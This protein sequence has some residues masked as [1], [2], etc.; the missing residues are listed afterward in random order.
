MDALSK[1]LSTGALFGWIPL[2]LTLFTILPARRAVLVGSIAGWL[3][4]PPFGIDLPGLPN[5]DKA[6]AVSVGILLGTLFFQPARLVQFR[7]RW[8][9]LPMILWCACPFISSVLNG[10]GAYDGISMVIR[11]V[12]GWFFPYLVGRLYLTD[13]EG[14][15]ELAMGMIVSG[16]CLMPF[17]FLEMKMSPIMSK[18]VYGFGGLGYGEGTRYGIFRPRIFFGSGLELGLWM[19][20]VSLV[21]WWL[22]RTGQ[23]KSLWGIRG[24]MICAV[25]LFTTI[26]CRATGATALLLAA[27]AALWISHRTGRKWAMWALLL[28]APFYCFV[29]V[30]NLWS[31][32]SAVDLV[33]TITNED[34]AHSLEYRLVNE[35]LLIAKALQQPIFGWG[36][37]GRSFVYDEWD[38]QLSVVDGMWMAALGGFGMVGLITLTTALLLPAALFLGRFSVKQWDQPSLAPAAA[39]AVVVDLCL[40]DGLFNGMLNVIYI[41]AAGGLVNIVALKMALPVPPTGPATISWEQ[42]VAHYRNLGRTLKDRARYLEAKTAWS[43]ALDLLTKLASAQSNPPALRLQ[44]CDCANDLAWLLVNSPDAAARDPGSAVALA[45]QTT[46][47]HPECGTYWN[48]LGAAY[49]R[50]DQFEAAIS[51]LNRATALT[52]G[53]TAFDHFFLAMAHVRLGNI[54]QAEQSVALAVRWMEQHYPGHPELIR[55]RDEAGAAASVSTHRAL[56]VR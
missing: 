50:I 33:R 40:L 23:L 45:S 29:R 46:A 52:E 55:L 28:A 1:L 49:Y 11:Q 42:Q 6:A 5:Y 13:V 22:W 8:F 43:Y 26:A 41:I 37:W 14:L 20:T 9:D 7:F 3:L 34:R 2:V 38:H 4:L 18:L 12:M 30:N 32:A 48:T 21:T 10:L 24:G 53:G 47:A 15:R 16:L 31:G 25:V 27:M 56:A 19:N 17:C 44:W 35:D 54:Q 51:A 39:I 36:G